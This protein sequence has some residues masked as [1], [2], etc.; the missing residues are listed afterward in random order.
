MSASRD[1]GSYR[2]RA[3]VLELVETGGNFDWAVSGRVWCRLD[4]TGKL[5][6][7]AKTGL[8][9][10]GYKISM[11]DRPLTLHN[12]LRIGGRHFF[13]TALDRSVRGFLEVEAV[14]VP[15]VTATAYPNEPENAFTFPACLTELYVKH[16]QGEPFAENII[17]YVLVT[18][19]PVVIVPG[20][21]VE[22]T[23]S[24]CDE[25]KR[26]PVITAH[27]LDEAKNEYVLRKET[28]LYG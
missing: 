18:P 19:K 10:E 7:F 16:V 1:I 12:A 26:F 14:S 9:A 4:R 23:R 20:S 22:L 8:A 13:I 24:D 5:S 25:G 21:L 6:I 3:D 2:E 15:L 17:D 28:D 11:R 27:T